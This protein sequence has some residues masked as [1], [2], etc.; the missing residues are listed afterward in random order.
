MRAKIA[1][2]RNSSHNAPH[3]LG[4]HRA[5]QPGTSAYCDPKKRPF[6][7]AVQPFGQLAPAP[8]RRRN[9]RSCGRLGLRLCLVLGE[10]EI[11]LRHCVMKCSDFVANGGL[12]EGYA[13]LRLLAISLCHGL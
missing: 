8:P 1:E 10:P 11:A 13:F 6:R 4:T 3:P 12:G 7:E 2:S 9:I 5:P